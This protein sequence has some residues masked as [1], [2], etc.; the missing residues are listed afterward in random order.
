M[1]LPRSQGLGVRGRALQ[2]G[3]LR[4]RRCQGWCARGRSVSRS[5]MTDMRIL[6]QAC[7]PL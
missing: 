7:M 5:V 2:N 4:V 6:M 1:D 3:Q